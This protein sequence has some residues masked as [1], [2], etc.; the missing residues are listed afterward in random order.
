MKD[1]VGD[2]FML[3]FLPMEWKIASGSCQCCTL[4]FSISYKG[5]CEGEVN[6]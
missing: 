2:P 6:N 1:T 4:Q 3:N 5:C